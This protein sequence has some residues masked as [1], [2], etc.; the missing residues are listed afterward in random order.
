[1]NPGPARLACVILVV[2]WVSLLPAQ[3]PKE[4]AWKYHEP[5][6]GKPRQAKDFELLGAGA[7]DYVKY[8]KDG[9]RIALPAGKSR[10]VTGVATTFGL[11]GDFDVSVRYEILQEPEP[12][13]AGTPNIGT[14]ISLSVK[15][16][17]ASEVAIRRKVTPKDP[18]FILT[19]RTMRPEGEAKS[20]SKGGMFPVKEKKGRLRLE[21]KGAEVT[22]YQSEGDDKEFKLLTTFAFVADDVKAVQLF[23]D[24]SSPKAALEV[25]FTDLHIAAKAM[26]PKAPAPNKRP[27]EPTPKSAPPAAPAPANPPNAAATAEPSSATPITSSVLLGHPAKPAAAVPRPADSLLYRSTLDRQ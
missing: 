18:V 17:A 1:M 14:R 5:F 25:R 23:G 20:L 3:E 24:T 4:H 2:G 7:A 15:T 26:V 13:D 10:P 19:W 22:Y 11:S 9:V 21:R 8:E 16:D 27:P 12:A 6:Q